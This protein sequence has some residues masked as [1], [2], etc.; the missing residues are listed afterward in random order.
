M[1]KYRLLALVASGALILALGGLVSAASVEPTFH[2]GNITIEGGGQNDAA[3]CDPADAIFLNGGDTPETEG[4]SDNGVT[5]TVTYHDSDDGLDFEADGGLVTI[6]YVKGSN[7]YNEYNYGSPGVAS[8]TDLFAP[9]AGGSEDPS[10]VSHLVFCTEE[11][12]EETEAPSFEQ[13]EEAQTDVPSQPASEEASEEAS[14]EQSE[15]AFTQP[16][17]DALGAGRTSAPADGAWLLVVALGV[18]L[19]SIVVLTPAR[20]RNR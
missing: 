17:T 12:E 4:T 11:A 10:Q 3:A 2:P 9:D 14:F 1:K 18:L 20:A 6:V 7:G 13:S 16:P 8:D 19:A 5:V 15:G